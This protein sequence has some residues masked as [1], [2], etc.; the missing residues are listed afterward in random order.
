MVF[1][2]AACVDMPIGVTPGDIYVRIY[3]PVD[4]V[5]LEPTK[6]APV[7]G[8]VFGGMEFPAVAMA[9]N[10]EFLQVRTPWW[11]DVWVVGPPEFATFENGSCA[12]LPN[13]S[14]YLQPK[15]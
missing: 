11:G 5:R 14:L 9:E 6:H 13:R 2:L 8:F 7:I 10:C 3:M 15:G 12:D 4:P 1:Q